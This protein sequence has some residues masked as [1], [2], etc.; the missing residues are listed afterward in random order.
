MRISSFVL[1]SLLAACSTP[2]LPDAKPQPRG[3]VLRWQARAGESGVIPHGALQGELDAHRART[4]AMLQSTGPT[5][6]TL[7]GPGNIGGRMRSILVHPTTPATMWVGS[8][9]G[10]V[11]KSTNAGA[12]WSML[13][14]LPAVLAVTCMVLEPGNPDVLYAGTGEQCFFSNVEGSSNSAV[15][16]GAG[17]FKSL[18]GGQ[19]WT[20]LPST[21]SA[22]WNAVSRLAINPVN[23]AILVATTISGIWRTTDG[24]TTWS[25]RTTTKTL[26]V[27]ID[28]ND[29]SKYV[30][31]RADGIA[32]YSTDGGVTWT[33]APAFASATRIEL[34]YA[35]AT[36]GMVYANVSTSGSVRVWRSTNGGQTYAQQTTG[37]VVSILGNYTSAL[38]IDPTNSNRLVVGGLDLYRSTNAGVNFTKISAWAS[39]PNSAHADHHEM[40]AHPLYDGVANTTVYFATDGG[41]QRASNVL[42]VANTSGWTNLNNNLAITQLYGCAINPT[43][44]VVLGGAQDNGTSRGTPV[45]GVSGWTQPG[46]GDG[47]YCAAD[48][49]DPN[50]FYMQYQN[51]GL[52]RSTNAG[53][54]AGSS[55]RGAISEADPNFMAYILLDPN[56]SNRLYACGARLWRTNNAKTGSPPTWTSVKPALSCVA[57]DPRGPRPDH[58]VNNPPCNISTVAVARGNSNVVW[59]GHNNG[60][61]FV[62]TNALAVTPTWTKVDDNPTALPNRWVSRIA[63]DHGDHNQVTVSFLGFTANNVW[64]T[65]NAGVAWSARSGSGAT[66]LPAV[67]VSCIAQHRVARSRYYAGTDLGLYHSEDDGLTWAPALGGPTI[68]PIE[69]LQWRTDRTLVVATHGRS[70]WSC[71]VDPASVTLVGSGCGIAS[72]PSLAVAAPVLGAQQ[73]YTL[74]GASPLAPVTL[75][76]AVGPASPTSIGPCTVQP[77]LAGLIALSIGTT[78]GS[79]AFA[80]SLLIPADPSLVGGVMTA[81][82]LIAV[83]GGPLLQFAELSNGAEMTFGF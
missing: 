83:S 53:V 44:G 80:S 73:S 58:Y 28:P 68:V 54:S 75:L 78:N 10:G 50:I 45:S 70:I 13:P 59:V 52:S 71:D 7:L 82:E 5:N 30:A 16:Q 12:N 61:V 51:I 64:R 31:G 55:I 6:W 8:V 49:N 66:A 57:S 62:S 77:A 36:P 23:P 81:Q 56:D 22:A 32:Q 42:T 48:P 34:E 18:D 9:G 24:G 11:W 3:A 25:Q 39:Y 20:Q 2:T 43:S 37:N 26:D 19:S 67:P 29:P 74:S 38:W 72:A 47:S 17:V 65:T 79:G 60:D 40:V 15:S 63:I 14:D 35:R 76:L 21:T 1:G 33:N 69:D 41:I 46:G 4:A 27:E